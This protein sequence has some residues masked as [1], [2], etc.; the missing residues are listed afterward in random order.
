M[1]LFD[2][3]FNPQSIF[4]MLFFNVKSVLIYS[5]L[6]ELE[7]K[8]PKMYE[9]W[10][11][12]SKV[13]YNFDLDVIHAVA[14]TMTD[15]TPVYGQKIY[16][17]NAINYPEFSRILAITY[18][19]A[20]SESGELKRQLKKIANED[21]SIVIEQFMYLLDEMSKEDSKSSPQV[22]SI[23]CGHN[24][25]SHDI[26]LLM[27][28]YMF[29]RKGFQT[30][31]RLPYLLKRAFNIKPWESGIIDTVN[32][33]KFNG[34]DY[35]PLMLVADFIGLKKTVD[36]LPNDELSKYYWKNVGEKPNETLEFVSLQ[37]ATQ[38]NLVIQLMNELR[39]I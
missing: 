37:S 33:W 6:K 7:A 29:H 4:D 18:A 23:L 14:S 20:Y 31:K 13:K 32:V 30:V 16:E 36:L 5:T 34:F 10:K 17:D 24:I 19:T 39:Q 38:T 26:P 28:R 15:D 12:L 22:F 3:V 27:K 35:S 11:Y 21:E 25:I 2:D 1:A 8:N 9:R